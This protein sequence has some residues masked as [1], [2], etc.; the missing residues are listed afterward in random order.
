MFSSGE[1]KLPFENLPRLILS[2]V[3]TEVV[4]TQNRELVLGH[5]QAICEPASSFA[6]RQS[7]MNRSRS[8]R[9]TPPGQEP[10]GASGFFR[11]TR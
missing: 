10:P 9:P 5:P 3:S 2:W 11:E 1:T 7:A 4:R 6:M 8:S